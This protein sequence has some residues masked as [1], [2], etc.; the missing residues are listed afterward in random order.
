MQWNISDRRFC[1][2]ELGD[3]DPDH[4]SFASLH[5]VVFRF[6]FAALH[7]LLSGA[8][9]K[10]DQII[11]TMRKQWRISSSGSALK[12]LSMGYQRNGRRLVGVLTSKARIV[13]RSQLDPDTIRHP[14]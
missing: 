3:H 7:D 11:L 5:G 14:G 8:E 10:T 1:G 6:F 13:H 2:L 12:A 4:C 9:S